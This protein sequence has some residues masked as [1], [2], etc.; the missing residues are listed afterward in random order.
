[1]PN[2]LDQLREQRAT[3]RTERDQILTRAAAEQRDPS[4]EELAQYQAHD[5][6]EREASDALEAERD[7]QLAEVRA[8]ATRRPGQTL[9]RQAA[10]TASAFRSAIFAKNPAPIEVYAEQMADE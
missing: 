6:A 8:M 4:P 3:A 9:T 5:L 10:E 1:V 2:L 7:R